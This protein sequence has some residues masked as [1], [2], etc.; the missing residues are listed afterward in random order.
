MER[1]SKEK[2]DTRTN[3]HANTIYT[4]EYVD[5][6]TVCD[7]CLKLYFVTVH[8]ANIKIRTQSEV[9]GRNAHALEHS[10]KDSSVLIS[11]SA[12]TGAHT[13]TQNKSV[14]R[15]STRAWLG[16]SSVFRLGCFEFQRGVH[17]RKPARRECPRI[18]GGAQ[19][20]DNLGLMEKAGSKARAP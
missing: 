4:L 11:P 18:H 9:Q 15:S 17:E 10:A 1:I 7:L 14:A 16:K 12:H 5:V 20:E 3:T 8:P 19:C 6:E 13:H 2:C